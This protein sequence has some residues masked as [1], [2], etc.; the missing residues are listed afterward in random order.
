MVDNLK[1]TGYYNRHSNVLEYKQNKSNFEK[2]RHS[3]G[4]IRPEEEEDNKQS[5]KINTHRPRPKLNH[6]YQKRFRSYIDQEESPTGM[7]SPVERTGKNVYT[8]QFRLDFL[9]SSFF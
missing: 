8:E 4:V 7:D 5:Y 2:Q 3:I 1:M 6:N 9:F